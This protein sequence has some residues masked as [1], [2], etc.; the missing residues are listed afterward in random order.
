MHRTPRIGTVVDR[1]R[2]DAG[3]GLIEIVVSMFLIALLSLSI[4]PLLIQGM[5]TS[6]D[7]ATQAAA[8]QLANDQVNRAQAA[9]PDC[10]AVSALA[11]DHTLTDAREVVLVATTEVDSCSATPA[12]VGV[13]TTVVR[14]DTGRTVATAETL[15]LVGVAE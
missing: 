5:R 9:G 7:N 11:G 15:V 6:A 3:L 14:Q 12:V 13:T 1:L 2:S 10:S 4:A 8:T